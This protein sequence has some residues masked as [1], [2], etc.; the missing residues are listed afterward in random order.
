MCTLYNATGRWIVLQRLLYNKL[1]RLATTSI[2]K[3]LSVPFHLI[4]PVRIYTTIFIRYLYT[5]NDY[6][7]NNIF[8]FIITYPNCWHLDNVLYFEI[9]FHFLSVGIGTLKLLSTHLGTLIFLQ[10]SPCR[11][12]LMWTLT[13]WSPTT[14]YLTKILMII[15]LISLNDS[16]IKYY[17]YIHTKWKNKEKYWVC[18]WTF[19]D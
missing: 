12:Y 17:N 15:S 1:I 9:S 4:L 11:D 10:F 7:F 18:I 2:N 19:F 6:L 3:R 13:V 14:N 8:Q 5:I 16:M